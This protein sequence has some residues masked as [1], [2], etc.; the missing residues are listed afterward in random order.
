LI[1]VIEHKGEC[2]VDK[3][4]ILYRLIVYINVKTFDIKDL[5]AILKIADYYFIETDDS[6]S[7]DFFSLNILDKWLIVRT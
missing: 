2:Y 6:D 5:L 4:D 3:A 7:V 1:N